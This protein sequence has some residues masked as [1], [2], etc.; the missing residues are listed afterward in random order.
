MWVG[1]RCGEASEQQGVCG[2][3]GGG[4]GEEAPEAVGAV[5]GQPIRSVISLK[6]V[7]IRLRHGAMIFSRMEGMAARCFLPGGTSTAVPRAAWEPAKARPLKP[8]SAKQVTGGRPGFQQVRGGLPLVPGG[9]HDGP[10]ADDPAAQAGSGGQPEAAAPLRV[11]GVAAEPGGQVVGRPSPAVRAA[12]PGW[13]P[14]RQRGRTGLLAA[15]FGQP[16][17]QRDPELLKRSPQPADPAVGLALVRQHREQV[18]PVPGRLGQ[19]SGLAAPAQQVP[20][21]GDGQQLGVTAG[22]ARS[23]P[24]RDR[25]GTALTRL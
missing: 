16:G 25:A 22:R 14:D 4:P 15:V 18:A 21:H 6:V 19:E 1:L 5:P 2:E 7:S 12:D 24:G 10:G 3:G 20:G 9:G 11:G 13:V 8:L 17:R 23:R